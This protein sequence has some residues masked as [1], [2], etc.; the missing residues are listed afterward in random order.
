MGARSL[1]RTEYVRS[2]AKLRA[3]GPAR[4]VDPQEVDH[5]ASAVQEARGRASAGAMGQLKL[6]LAHLPAAAHSVDRH[7]DL[8][9][10]PVRERQHVGEYPG[11]QGALPGDGSDRLQPA[12]TTE[13]PAGECER[14]PE[15]AS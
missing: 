12:A 13:R 10:R 4:D 3:R 15:A 8:H 14:Q 2:P 7:A 5:L 6:E 11:A 9:A 1:I